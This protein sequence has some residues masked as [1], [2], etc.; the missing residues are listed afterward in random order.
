LVC[1]LIDLFVQFLIAYFQ[2]SALLPLTFTHPTQHPLRQ[3]RSVV[4]TN[5]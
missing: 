2:T 3:G 5:C 1:N 4:I